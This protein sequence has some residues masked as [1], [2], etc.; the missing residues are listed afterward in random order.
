MPN[1]TI[2][3]HQFM[4]DGAA[5]TTAVIV[6]VAVLAVF[7]IAYTNVISRAGYSRWW[8][9]IM[10]VPIVNLVFLLLFC[11]KEWPIQRELR[12]LRE[13]RAQNGGYGQ[14]GSGQAG[15]GQAGYG[16]PGYPGGYPQSGGQPQSGGYPQ[17]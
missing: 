12:A 8:I 17:P 15:Y 7:L 5:L 10:L 11:F 16:Q 3:T 13:F 6:G 1:T 4:I 14:V 9:L 2:T